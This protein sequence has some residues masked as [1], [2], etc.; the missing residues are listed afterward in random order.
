MRLGC[1]L[2]VD[3]EKKINRRFSDTLNP[4]MTFDNDEL[5]AMDAE[6][7]DAFDDISS[8]ESTD[9]SNRD[10]QIRKLVLKTF[11]TFTL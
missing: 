5:N 4:L 11:I 3:V 6:I 10:K 9:E 8:D 2:S 1:L 7:D